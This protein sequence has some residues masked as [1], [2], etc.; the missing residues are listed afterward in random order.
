MA[1]FMDDFVEIPGTGVRFGFDAL[2][3]L[4]PGL[5]D[6]L[7]SL[8]S[9]YILKAASAAGV[10]RITLLRMAA[11]IGIDMICGSIPVLGDVFDVFWKAN[12]KNVELLARHT[13]ATP[14]EERRA[15]SGDWL[16]VSGLIAGLAALLV[17]C[18]TILFG[19]W[20]SL[21]KLWHG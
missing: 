17:G 19:I 11:N 20:A 18:I 15:R 14:A 9:L 6:T 10:P 1:R 3:G 5:G 8:V 12:I 13:Q 16:F 21:W 2:L 7:S 4:I